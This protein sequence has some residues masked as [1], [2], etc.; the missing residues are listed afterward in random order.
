MNTLK[1]YPERIDNVKFLELEGESIIYS[2][3][4]PKGHYLN[5]TATLIWKCC[6]GKHDVEDMK[7]KVLEL[8]E[9][10]KEQVRVDVEEIL[11]NFYEAKLLKE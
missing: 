11:S 2:P 6:D 9:A 10:E 5:Q 8:Y 7:K 3:H 4:N 1:K